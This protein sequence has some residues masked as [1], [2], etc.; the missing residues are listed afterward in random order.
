MELSV[1]I[2]NY[3]AGPFLEACVHSAINATQQI[4]AEII[5]ADNQSTDGSI[6]FI[7]RQFTDVK[8]LRFDQNHGFAIG[9]NIAVA[10]STGKFLCI[11]NPDTIVG[12]QVFENCLAFAKA[13]NEKTP[14]GFMGCRLIDGS[15]SFLPES[16]R[17]IPTPKVARQKMLGNDAG[18]YF[19]E[20]VERDRGK[21]EVLVG[22]FMFCKR[23]VYN[24]CGGFD[25]R[26]FMYGED[27]DLSVTA[28][29]KGYVNYYL[30]DQ[31]VIHFKGES[32]IRD[33]KNNERFYG[34]MKLFYEK[35]FKNNFLESWTISLAVKALALFPPRV[36]QERVPQM[37][38][39]ASVLVSDDEKLAQH[40][41][42]SVNSI[43][44]LKKSENIGLVI[45]DLKNVSASQV[46]SF[47]AQ[48]SKKYHYRFLN[49]VN[50]KIYGS[51]HSD[52]RGK[53]TPLDQIR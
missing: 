3:N 53:V 47:M 16:K 7:E 5:V 15:G 11:L 32:T 20:L 18:Y 4:Q 37:I 40:F 8:I 24:D 49:Q 26:Y 10:H 17:H 28:L 21:T 51:D 43:D 14:L 22:A 31:I 12:E 13:Y 45:W 48:N 1:V 41:D 33:K 34:A 6:D 50:T 35:H 23:N 30:G 19:K 27:I 29:K 52:L 46:I 9:N 39:G 42:F 25:E 38:E 36:V 44:E 2:L